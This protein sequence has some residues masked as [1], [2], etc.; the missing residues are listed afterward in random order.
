MIERELKLS[1]PPRFRPPDLDGLVAGISAVPREPV[2]LRAVYYD[3]RDLRLIRWGCTLRHRS[4]EGWTVK[5]PGGSDDGLLTRS[6]LH[7]EGS[8]RHPPAQALELV[9]AYTRSAPLEVVAR[10][11]TLRRTVELRD[12]WGT[13]VAE[14]VDDEVSVIDGHRV[15]ERFRELEIELA[16]G[17][18]GDE[19]LAACVERMEAEG[20]TT[21]PPTPKLVRAVGPRALEPPEV[22]PAPADPH[23]TAGEVVAAAISR[24]VAR[25]LRHDPGVVLG[26]DPEDV[27]QARVALRRLRSDLRTF[28]P[29]VEQAPRDHLRAEASWFGG[30]LGDVRDAEVLHD[31]LVRDAGALPAEEGAVL[32]A[33]T[34]QLEADRDRA[35]AALLEARRGERF[36]GLCEEMVRTAAAPPLTELAAGPA[37]GVL[38]ALL[39]RPWRRLRRAARALDGDSRDEDL[40]RLRILCKRLR[41]AAEAVAPVAGKRARRLAR[42]A[43]RLQDV[44]GEHQDATI[45]EAWLRRT[46][47]DASPAEAFAAGEAYARQMVVAERARQDWPKA[48]R[49]L[50]RAADTA[51]LKRARQAQRAGQN[52]NMPAAPEPVAEREAEPVTHEPAAEPEPVVQPMRSVV[53]EPAAPTLGPEPGHELAREAGAVERPAPREAADVP[54]HDPVE[55][56]PWRTPG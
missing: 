20:A 48:W 3:T 31:A 1:V 18:G 17:Y 56:P 24:S 45:A 32:R 29:L 49:R 16:Q 42:G 13:R 37:D 51:W 55:H 33:M 7:F 21:A 26:D 39:A 40:H 11:R 35:R 23:S 50:R 8:P 25:F 52:G 47:A 34:A 46:A 6:E 54:E 22:D 9:R 19:L 10:M 30:L 44:L 4:E 2:A 15:A 41:Y 14:V 27:H 12:K 43:R 5:L 38:P 53:E 36:L 28:A